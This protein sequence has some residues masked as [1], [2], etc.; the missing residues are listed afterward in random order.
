MPSDLPSKAFCREDTEDHVK[1]GIPDM[2]V[3]SAY[4]ETATLLAFHLQAGGKLAE[5]STFR[6]L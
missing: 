1:T 6:F 4:S 5:R 2:L 3:K